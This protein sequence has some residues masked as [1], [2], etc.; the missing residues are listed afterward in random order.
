MM[1]HRAQD[2]APYEPGQTVEIA[3]SEDPD[4]PV[5]MQGEVADVVS[6]SS[7][8]TVLVDYPSG[9]QVGIRDPIGGGIAYVD[10]GD[11]IR[12]ARDEFPVY[13]MNCGELVGQSEVPDSHGVCKECREELFLGADLTP[14]EEERLEKI[15][16]RWVPYSERRG[17]VM[18]SRVSRGPMRNTDRFQE[19]KLNR[20]TSHAAEREAYGTMFDKYVAALHTVE[21]RADRRLAR[22]RHVAQPPP[23]LFDVPDVEVGLVDTFPGEPGE[24]GEI[25]TPDMVNLETV[26]PEHIEDIEAQVD[27]L[28]GELGEVGEEEAA[29]AAGKAGESLEDAGEAVGEEGEEEISEEGPEE[30]EVEEEP[31]EEEELETEARLNFLT[32]RSRG[33][34]YPHNQK[35]KKRNRSQCR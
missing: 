29:E 7:D 20:I 24:E 3:T 31:E 4:L 21:E 5:G 2:Q 16:S 23:M 11:L 1:T 18:R 30:E 28:E 22:T 25:I 10:A 6:V 34:K 12:L 8:P 9:W 19:R 17:V 32:L 15:R 13:C 33:W 35:G 27:A 14:E 26:T